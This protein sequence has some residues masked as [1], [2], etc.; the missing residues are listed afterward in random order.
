MS[1]A[2]EISHLRKQYGEVVAVED[3][4]GI[5]NFE[6]LLFRQFFFIDSA[7]SDCESKGASTEHPAEI[8]AGAQHPSSLV[9]AP[10]NPRKFG[11]Y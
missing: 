4:S 6:N 10:S 8:P 2:I 7:R 5:I 9:E 3:I 1:D 11:F